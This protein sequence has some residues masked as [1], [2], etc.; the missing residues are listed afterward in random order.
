MIEYC[1]NFLALIDRI[2]RNSI[3]TCRLNYGVE[4]R[5]LLIWKRK[6]KISRL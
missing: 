3:F 6:K 4:L 2:A 5:V 1:Y